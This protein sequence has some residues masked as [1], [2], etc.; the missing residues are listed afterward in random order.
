MRLTPIA[1]TIAFAT[2]AAV[3]AHA[4]HMFGRSVEAPKEWPDGPNKRFFKGLQRP[5]N[6]LRQWDD[7]QPVTCCG[8]ADMVKTRFKVEAGNG[9]H[10][11]DI[12]YA[13]LEEKWVRIPEK[14]VPDFAPDG[15]AYLFVFKITDRNGFQ[16]NE[17]VCFVRPKG[18]L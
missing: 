18:G 16:F 15:Q 12:W 3:S 6:H 8:E 1:A 2:G 10:P 17:I 11:N 14:I 9:F 5:D 13:W 7:N 4:Q